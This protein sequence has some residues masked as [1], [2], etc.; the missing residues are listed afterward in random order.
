MKLESSDNM[1][2]I[3][4]DERLDSDN[5]P[6]CEKKITGYLNEHENIKGARIDAKDLRYISS[7]GIRILLMI[8]KRIN[9]MQIINVSD[10]VYDII[11]I[12]GMED[13]FGLKKAE[14][15]PDRKSVV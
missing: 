12:T 6:E 11:S 7:A 15:M 10:D 1:I 5:A 9:D 14:I 13:V 4:L 2:R 8:K 3:S